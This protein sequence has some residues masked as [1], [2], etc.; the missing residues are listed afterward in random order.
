MIRSLTIIENKDENG[1]IEYS[2]NG[3]LPLMDAAAALVLIA[4]R[5]NPATPPKKEGGP[6]GSG[7]PE[8]G[9]DRL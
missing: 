8:E 7:Q 5:A 3:D 4:Y 6:E 9:Q 1:K 2:A